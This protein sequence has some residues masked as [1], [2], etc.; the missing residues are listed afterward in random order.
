MLAPPRPP[1]DELELLIRE[2]RARQRRRRILGS[3]IALV[4]AIGLAV[5]AVLAGSARPH[6]L[7]GQHPSRLASGHCRSDQLRLSGGF[8]GAAAGNAWFDFA[9]TNVSGTSCTL[10]G[11]PLL[12]LRFAHRR[13]LVLRARTRYVSRHGRVVPV[14]RVVLPPSGAA[15]FAAH[16]LSTHDGGAPCPQTADVV[17][18][19]PGDE[20]PVAAH[21]ARMADV[22]AVVWACK[23][24]A[25]VAPLAAG[26]TRRY[27]TR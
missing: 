4:A 25:W 7:G 24:K 2:A 20:T 18:I 6:R 21:L 22:P 27:D 12:E 8:G 14:R 16:V 11:W 19:P 10:R 1:L 17:A 5:F 13:V 3:G 15:S 23:G 26:A 9:L